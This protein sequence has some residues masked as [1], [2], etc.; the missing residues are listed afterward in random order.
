M[1]EIRRD[2]TTLKTDVA[3]VQQQLRDLTEKFTRTSV[4]TI[5]YSS[6]SLH[7]NIVSYIIIYHT[8]L[9]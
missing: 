8:I 5:L 3:Q 9:K 2:V 6:F 4:L 1:A 7:C